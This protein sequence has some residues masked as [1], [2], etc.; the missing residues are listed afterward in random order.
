MGN[1]M[2]FPHK[3]DVELVESLMSANN[4]TDGWQGFL[5]KL[6]QHFNLNTCNLYMV[7][8]NTHSIRF[9]D[10]SGIKPSDIQ[11]NRYFETYFA[12]DRVHMQMLSGPE[13][14]WLTP[15]LMP[16]R[17]ELESTRAYIEWAQPNDFIYSTGTVLF[18]KNSSICALHFNRNGK[19]PPFTQEEEDRFTILAP[20]IS[21][22]VAL[23][24][25]IA[26]FS[27]NNGRIKAMLNTFRFPVAVLNEFGELIS[28]NSKMGA[29]LHDSSTIAINEENRLVL[30]ASKEDAALQLS[31]T[32]SVSVAK[33]HS[34]DYSREAI[35]LGSA[36]GRSTVSIGTC[37]LVEKDQASDDI[38]VGA[39]VYVISNNI[40][41]SISKSQLQTI[42]SFTEAEAQ[43]CHLFASNMSLKEIA[44]HEGKSVN[45][46]KEQIKNCYVKTSTKNQVEL[47]NLISSLPLH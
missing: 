22:A 23:R 25:H 3:D 15:N 34:L 17:A 10:W 28:V 30:A 41:E 37:E 12:T 44:V 24:L 46:V 31:I 8:A 9:Q 14:K 43:C 20:Y 38:F 33:D 32:E 16:N 36:N 19:Q 29:V 27:G 40:M 1:A 13:G 4:A 11:M 6:T 5:D 21:K 2:E 39:M 18:R 35:H 42:F 7:N 47:I 45:T 26:E